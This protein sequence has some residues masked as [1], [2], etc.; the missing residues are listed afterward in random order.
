MFHDHSLKSTC[1]FHTHTVITK[2]IDKEW[3]KEKRITATTTIASCQFGSIR[4]SDSCPKAK[5]QSSESIE[6]F[7]FSIDRIMFIF[8]VFCFPSYLSQYKREFP[9]RYDDQKWTIT[10]KYTLQL[11]KKNAKQKLSNLIAV[12]FAVDFFGTY[13]VIN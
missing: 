12:D 4:F 2:T 7:S 6:S 10:K 9:L 11:I 1:S 5:P 8:W 13:N 3:K